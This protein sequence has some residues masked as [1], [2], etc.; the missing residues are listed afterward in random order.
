MRLV[1]IYACICRKQNTKHTARERKR[2]HR[3]RLR[4]AGHSPIHRLAMA[5][6][7]R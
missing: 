4:F 2:H 6:G 5:M 7:R 1:L 3:L